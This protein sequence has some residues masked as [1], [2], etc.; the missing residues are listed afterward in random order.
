[1][2]ARVYLY[3]LRRG[4][5]IIATGHLNQDQPLEVGE[6]IGVAGHTGIIRE[7]IPRVDH[8]PVRLIVELLPGPSST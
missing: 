2:R 3:E 6:R 4:D 1:M 7:I 8:N 5:Q